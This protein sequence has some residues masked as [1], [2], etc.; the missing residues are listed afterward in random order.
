MLVHGEH[1]FPCPCLNEYGRL[2]I[3]LELGLGIRAGFAR[4]CFFGYG[5]GY[6]RSVTVRRDNSGYH[7]EYEQ[8]NSKKPAFGFHGTI[9]PKTFP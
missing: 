7:A 8:Q 4:P 9:T 5:F 1:H 3:D 2:G 6:F